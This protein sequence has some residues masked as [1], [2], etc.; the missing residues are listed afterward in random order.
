M[1]KIILMLFMLMGF[2]ASVNAAQQY[3]DG[4]IAHL[5][6]IIQDNDLR[7]EQRFMAQESAN[8]LALA[9]QKEALSTALS[10]Q[11]EASAKSE[12]SAEQHF[13][14]LSDQL[15]QLQ[16]RVDQSYGKDVGGS[17]LWGYLVA[18][19]GLLFGALNI[20]ALVHVGSRSGQITNRR[21][22]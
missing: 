17:A 6:E 9:A 16:T 21:T 2:C 14:S 3:A 5:R 15:T 8:A 1:K 19:I 20:W 7:Y 4:S 22:K 13:K 18:G 11:K 10:A 12:I